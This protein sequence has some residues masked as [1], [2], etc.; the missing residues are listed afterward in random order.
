MGAVSVS[1]FLM[2]YVWFIL[3][4]VLVF[5]LL[6]ARFYERFAHEQTYFRLFSVPLV[7]FG[8]ATVRY[9]S[10]DRIGGDVLADLLLA[11]AGLVLTGLCLLLYSLMTHNR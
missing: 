4:I 11:A 6:I 10:L 5:L 7:L 8:L 2:L 9:S 1:Q 3:A